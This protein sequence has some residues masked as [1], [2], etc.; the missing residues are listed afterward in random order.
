VPDSNP[1]GDG[2]RGL[3]TSQRRVGKVRKIF[4]N[5]G[6]QFDRAAGERQAVIAEDCRSRERPGFL[7]EIEPA[8]QQQ[9]VQTP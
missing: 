7:P 2:L 4:G 5:G 1:A 8:K 9:P 6:R 3:V